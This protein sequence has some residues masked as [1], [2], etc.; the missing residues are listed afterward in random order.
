MLTPLQYTDHLI[1][2]AGPQRRAMVVRLR[3]LAI[4]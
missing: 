1:E 4:A 3:E 2:I